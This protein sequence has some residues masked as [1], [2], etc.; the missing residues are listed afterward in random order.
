MAWTFE[1]LLKSGAEFSA[2][3]GPVWTGSEL[4]F[5][6]IPR[7][8]IL[9]YDPKSGAIDVWAPTPIARTACAST[10]M[11]GY[12]VAALEGARSCVSTPTA[13]TRSS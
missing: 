4:R 12:S 10:L 11:V 5:T 13:R 6:H 7:S 3:E 8:R 1:I 2:T 9:R